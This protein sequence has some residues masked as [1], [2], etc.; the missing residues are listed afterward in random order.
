M[1]ACEW[2]PEAMMLAGAEGEV[3]VRGACGVERVGVLACGWVSI[4]REEEDDVSG[5]AALR[6]RCFPA[7]LG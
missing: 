6:P 3:R 4:G 1:Q 2:C 7:A 5:R